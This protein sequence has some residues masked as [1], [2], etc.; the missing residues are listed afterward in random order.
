[1]SRALAT[2]QKQPQQ[3]KR[4]GEVR[5]VLLL[6]SDKRVELLTRHPDNSPGTPW[7]QVGEPIPSGG[8][9]MARS[10]FVVFLS[11]P[12]RSRRKSLLVLSRG[13]TLACL[14]LLVP[15]Q[16]LAQSSFGFVN[17]ITVVPVPG[18]GHDYLHDLNEIVNP[19][20][21]SLSVRIE[22]P[23]P[24]ERG[25]N[26]PFYSFMYDSTQQFAV[27]Y[28][29]QSN[30]SYECGPD[31][32]TDAPSGEAPQA[33]T[34]VYPPM[35]FPYESIS[36]PA[37]S[38]G[39]LSGPNSM[40]ATRSEYGREEE[41]GSFW[42]CN[43]YQ[44]YSYEDPYGVI[45]DLGVYSLNNY[46]PTGACS[47]LGI[48]PNPISGDEQYKIVVTDTEADIVLPG[49]TLTA[50]G[51][52]MMIDTHGNS[53]ATLSPGSSGFLAMEDTNGNGVNGT[54]RTGSY[55]SFQPW[56][57][58]F[59]KTASR[60]FAGGATYNYTW[61]TAASKFAPASVDES[62]LL[63]GYD[64][65]CL[66]PKN[67]GIG[68]NPVVTR[69]E[70]PDGLYYTFTYDP[71]YG[72]LS[73]ITYPTGAYVQYTWGVNSLSDATGFS[74][75]GAY[76]NSY[77]N[78]IH[79][80]L[81]VNMNTSCLF[82]HDTPAITKRVVSYDGVHAAQEQDFSY[83]TNWPSGYNSGVWTSKQTTVTTKDL[84]TNGTPSFQ[85]IYNYSPYDVYF[86]L[87]SN[88]VSSPLVIENTVIYKDTSG[89][90]LRT[91]TK[92]WNYPNQLAG[93]CTTLPNGKTS[94]IFYQYEPYAL[95]DYNPEPINPEALT[96]N[97]LTDVA[98]YDYGSVT[99]PCQ[100]P[101]TTPTRETVTTYASFANTPLWPKFSMYYNNQNVNV[102]MPPMVDRPATVI[103][104]QNGTKI[105]ET[106]YSYD[107]TAVTSVSPAP[108]GHD[109]TNY[110]NGSTVPRGNP[111]T[112]TQK[113]FQGSVNCTNSITTITYDT[114][115]QALSVTDPNG[116]KTALSYTDNYTTDDG[117][118][119]GNTNTYLT[120]MTR[121]TTNGVAHIESFQWN[122]NK[123]ELRTLTDE[124][125]QPTSYQYVDPWWRLTSSSLPDGGSVTNTYSDAG[126][127]PSVMTTT[128]I[129]TG[130]NVQT[131][132]IMDAA[133][134]VIHN[135]LLSD[136]SGTDYTDTVYNGFGQVSSVS[137]PYR[138]TSD[139]TYGL[140]TYAYDSL[141]R[142]TLQGQPDGSLLQWCYNDVAS[143]GQTNCT[144][145]ASSQNGSDAW[146]D[147]SD[148][149]GNHWQRAY[150]AL[151]R[152]KSVRE[153]N[154]TTQ[155][156]SMETDYVYDGL[157]DLTSV[158]QNGSN[159]SYARN[160]TFS[161]DSLGRLISATNPESGNITYTYDL[162]SN[163]ASKVAPKPGQTGT[164]QV[165]TNYS[166]DALNRL[167]L[168]TYTGMTTQ[169]AQYGYDGT[170]LSGCTVAVPSIT[171]PT[172]LVGRRSAMCSNLSSSAFSYDQMGRVLFDARANQ[173]SSTQ[174]YTVGYTY[175]KNGALNTLTYPSGDVVTYTVGS[176][177]RV[178]QMSDPS[179]SYVGYS[180]TPATYT[181]NGALAGM[182]NG[183][184][185]AF[186]GITTSNIYNDR[187]QPILLSAAVGG[188]SIFSLC[189]DFHSGVAIN[190]TPCSFGKYTTGN[191]GNVFQIL[192]KFDSTRSTAFT[193]DTL[194]RISQAN[195]VTE[196]GANCWGEVYT[197][198]AWGN[199]YNRAAV[200]GMTGCT[201]ESLSA[202]VSTNN[203]LSILTYDA[204][205]NVANDG[206]GNQPTYDAENRI[207]TDA[208]VTY[209]YD[210]DGAR[211]EK[212][213]GIMYW[214]G[215]TGTLAETNLS[216]TINEE[217]IY[218]NGERIARVDRPSGTVHYYFS[219]H[220]GS[221][222][223]ITSATGTSPTY[224]YYYPYGGLFA[225][226]GS[227]PNRYKFTGKERDTESGLDSFGARY[228]ASSMGRF[229]TPDQRRLT[230]RD[231]IN[232][233]K[234]N[235]YAYTIN[236]PLRY[237]DP[238]GM[239]EMDIQL[240]AVIQ[241][242]SRTDP[243]RRTF[244]GDSNGSSR[245]SITV[246]IETDASIRPGNPIISATRG[247]AGQTKQ[248][249]ANGNVVR[250]G[251]ATE[252]LPTVTGTRDANGN[253]VLNF[254]ENAKNP[255]EPQS[256]PLGIRA[257]LNVT[258]PQDASSVTTV[259]TVSGAPSFGLNVST[260]GGADVNIPLQT[261]PASNFG[262]MM[263]LTQTNPIL[264]VTPLPPPPPPC[265]Q[266]G[267]GC[268]HP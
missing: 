166:Y 224:Y 95:S 62:A 27:T 256:L 4:V 25:F 146:I 29:Q 262:F 230:I 246:R 80:T 107:Q 253:A 8:G 257:D 205:G 209:D 232:P 208:G 164:A 227:D 99:T 198:D 39:V 91:V 244:A 265:V 200:S 87:G 76:V 57:D 149:L 142:K 215:P 192:N 167:Y 6:S 267:N 201:Y 73:E 203:Q 3:E 233:Q 225:T 178:T 134:H 1:M 191:N 60:T 169:E 100:R 53:V 150:D 97:V 268:N 33:L 147:F 110:G 17:N 163:L 242:P 89:N 238:N 121:P 186:A 65:L 213:S 70:E 251:Q 260:A 30:P 103:K 132:T 254:Q 136:P 94:G 153:P 96:T 210:A 47:F 20:N 157:N 13:A 250:T 78:P 248:L 258:V 129:S 24:K 234:W 264:N 155:A 189:Y 63:F 159:S 45:H 180:G 170:A 228:N 120:K 36:Y 11:S 40:L 207:S 148:E 51:G 218:F 101:T 252:G 154:G 71:T 182:V 12:V 126:P 188:S 137:N 43:V 104:Y 221:A 88:L 168:K 64:N 79:I 176:A 75:P 61:S 46:N 9:P 216:G 245:T 34:C 66:A 219:D 266:N 119:S 84:L 55:Q 54:G 193:Y 197:I 86:D 240:K 18:V 105:S 98:E 49:G 69:M 106:D 206:L 226:V 58:G 114:T 93:E 111:T 68:L 7:Q 156:P 162:N 181:P 42:T 21:G 249:D 151:G 135:E 138:S 118:P 255:L 83:A 41:E 26:Y 19:A 52:G 56:G 196:T 16:I 127:N 165:T 204:A 10:G 202:S 177:N 44:N 187:L 220:L 184:T 5:K 174:A 243:L 171:S 161:Y 241:A 247:T 236:N 211:M 72:L 35:Q 122:F 117:T 194:N 158:V 77:N 115:G 131:E 123:G 48:G 140:T 237:F 130:N 172:N 263:G 109:E 183:H 231:L 32:T 2:A 185:S 143:S 125:N 113:C 15:T 239:E 74:T 85:T 190:Q 128:L 59:A 28:E 50:G 160:R 217:Y 195:T 179:N 92:A 259:G 223:M 31:T 152:M 235:K 90:V 37:G 108:I 145:N 229:M 175:Y 102:S 38:Q 82:E 139:P 261:E 116:N 23:R 144:T 112:V 212:S 133:G 173:G 81:G 14:L 22:A 214:P 222:S 141:N 124:N 199:L 67:Y